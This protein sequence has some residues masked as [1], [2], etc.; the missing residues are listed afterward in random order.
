MQNYVKCIDPSDI[1]ILQTTL[2]VLFEQNCIINTNHFPLGT[3]FFGYYQEVCRHKLPGY[4]QR[5]TSEVRKGREWH[6]MLPFKGQNIG[7]YSVH[8]DKTTATLMMPHRANNLFPGYEYSY[9]YII[10]TNDFDYCS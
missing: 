9:K 4:Q 5:I 1:S 6:S 2:F 3:L 10:N 7:L 8:I